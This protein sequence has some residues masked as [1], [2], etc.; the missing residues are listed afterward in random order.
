MMGVSRRRG[1]LGAK[2]G[3]TERA[4]TLHGDRLGRR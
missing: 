2:E 3:K 4:V 1:K